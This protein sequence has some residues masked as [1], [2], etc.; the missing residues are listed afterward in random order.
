MIALPVDTHSDRFGGAHVATI[1]AAAI[2]TTAQR[3]TTYEASC[4]NALVVAKEI[5]E[6]QRTR[7]SVARGYSQTLATFSSGAPALGK[8]V[9][10]VIGESKEIMP[11]PVSI[12]WA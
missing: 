2:S 1:T 12:P 11:A 7:T 4:C 10:T 5:V 6:W 8:T 9:A 3:Q